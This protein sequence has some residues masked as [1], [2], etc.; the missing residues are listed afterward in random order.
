MVEKPRAAHGGGGEQPREGRGAGDPGLPADA[1]EVVAAVGGR[2]EDEPAGGELR[3]RLLQVLRRERGA[4]AVDDDHGARRRRRRDRRRR[5]RAARRARRR[6]APAV[7][8]ER[9]GRRAGPGRRAPRASAAARSV[10][11]S[12]ASAR[13]S[14]ASGHALGAVQRPAQQALVD[15][16]RAVVAERLREARLHGARASAVA[17]SP[18]SSGRSSVGAPASSLQYGERP[19]ERQHEAGSRTPPAVRQAARARPSQS[20]SGSDSGSGENMP[21]SERQPEAGG[22]SQRQR[23][24]P[25]PGVDHRQAEDEQREGPGEGL[26]GVLRGR[27]SCRRSTGRRRRRGPAPASGRSRES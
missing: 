18:R 22:E 25:V 2:A 12:G 9:R 11:P 13:I 8:S 14:A 5:R 4:V 21:S 3:E 19:P 26:G 27:G 10:R 24:E 7:T 6:A 15:G 16:E 23:R 1:D 17:P 20:A